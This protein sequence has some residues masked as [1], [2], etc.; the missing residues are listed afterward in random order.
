M[1]R[2]LRTRIQ[3]WNAIILALVIGTFGVLLYVQQRTRIMRSIDDEIRGAVAVL[4]G[5]LQA[6]SPRILRDYLDTDPDTLP[7]FPG[8][9]S[10]DSR[11]GRPGGPG[12]GNR[13]GPDGPPGGPEDGPF[14]DGPPAGGPPVDGPRRNGPRGDGP[15]RD[16][17]VLDSLPPDAPL[18]GMQGNRVR[19]LMEPLIK[20]HR[21]LHLP[22]TFHPRRMKEPHPLPYFYIWRADSSLV[23][24]SRPEDIPFPEIGST[25]ERRPPLEF[26]FRQRGTLREGFSPGAPG[27]VVLVGR[28]I[29]FDLHRLSTIGW[30]ITLSGFGAWMIGLVGGWMLSRGSTRPIETITDVAADI[31]GS[32]LSGR[33]DASMMDVEFAGLSRTLNETFERLQTAFERQRQFTADASHELRTPLSVL[34]THHELAL[35]KPRTPEEYQETIQTCQRAVERMNSLV[36]SLLVLARVDSNEDAAKHANFELGNVLENEIEKLEPVMAKAGLNFSSSLVSATVAG[37]M[38]QVGRVV[39]NLLTNAI[40]YSESGDNV[41][42]SMSSS[43]D[44]VTID[45]EDSGTGIPDEELARIFDRFYRVDK[46]RS[47]ETGGSGLGLS[48]CK[49]IIE[50]HNGS[51]SVESVAGKGSTFRVR[52]PLAG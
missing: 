18:P 43:D 23:K 46:E 40:H 37:D 9:G 21:D 48:I 22:D 52:L 4:A 51:I 35:S 47:R 19:G 31:S 38:H 33:I 30:W 41:S 42:V 3:I 8:P 2:S 20:L 34:Q 26:K 11:P 1:F 25:E 14:F 39:S 27:T 36:E 13:G 5:K 6:A 29:A 17:P 50:R 7:E 10:R 45:V 44:Y 12:R 16:D 28:D 15:M 24:S 49:S 32:N